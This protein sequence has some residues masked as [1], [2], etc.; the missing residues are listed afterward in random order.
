MRDAYTK[1]SA[2]HVSIDLS[3]TSEPLR[4]PEPGVV[5]DHTRGKIRR[6]AY[7]Y[8]RL[9]DS[10]RRVLEGLPSVTGADLLYRPAMAHPSMSAATPP[11]NLRGDYRSASADFRVEQDW[12]AYSPADT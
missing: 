1:L 4:I 2:G 11:S 10:R 7:W 3:E 8:R 9:R 6:A 12:A 5:D